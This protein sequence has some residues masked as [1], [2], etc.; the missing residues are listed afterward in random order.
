MIYREDFLKL[1]HIAPDMP[2][3]LYASTKSIFYPIE[4]ETLTDEMYRIDDPE[5]RNYLCD[6]AEIQRL[7]DIHLILPFSTTRCHIFSNSKENMKQVVIGPSSFFIH[8]VC[9]VTNNGTNTIWKNDRIFSTYDECMKY[10]WNK[11]DNYYSYS[12]IQAYVRH[13]KFTIT[14]LLQFFQKLSKMSV[15]CKCI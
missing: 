1:F 11:N 5:L 4:I 10:C 6:I 13:T 12:K 9:S 8:T 3:G 14:R 15:M 7:N 2:Y